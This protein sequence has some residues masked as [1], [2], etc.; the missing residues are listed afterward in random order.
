MVFPPHYTALKTS[1]SRRQSSRLRG[2]KRLSGGPNFEITH[3]SRFLQNSKFV[4]WGGQACRLKGARPPGHP[5]APTLKPAVSPRKS[6]TLLVVSDQRWKPV[7]SRFFDRQ[8]KNT[9]FF[10]ATKIYLNTTEIYISIGV[11]QAVYKKRH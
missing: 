2:A 7:E 4:D 6:R 3:N 10:L 1:Q 11:F 5:L 9:V 8:V